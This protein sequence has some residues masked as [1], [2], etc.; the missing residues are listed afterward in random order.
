MK[1]FDLDDYGFDVFNPFVR[2]KQRK[3]RK[4]VK[5]FKRRKRK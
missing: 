1:D 2:V 4:K 5:E 3:R